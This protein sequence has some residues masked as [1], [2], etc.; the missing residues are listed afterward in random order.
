MHDYY[1]M[2]VYFSKEDKVVI[3]MDGYVD[4]ILEYSRSDINR[5]FVSPAVE[6]LFTVSENPG[7]L[8]E[9]DR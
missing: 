2:I 1:G 7:L 4:D 6:H 8:I 3:I 5:E 9:G